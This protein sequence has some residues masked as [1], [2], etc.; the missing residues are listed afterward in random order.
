MCEWLRGSM[1]ISHWPGRGGSWG[2]L[3]SGMETGFVQ[4]RPE[5]EFRL[6]RAVA[7][8]HR[9]FF[10]RVNLQGGAEAPSGPRAGLVQVRQGSVVRATQSC[11]L[12]K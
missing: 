12:A 10:C 2:W 3:N 7:G 6:V 11:G 1:A 9:V 4:R 5:G 8:G